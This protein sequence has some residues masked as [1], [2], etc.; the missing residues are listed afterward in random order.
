MLRRLFKTTALIL[1]SSALITGLTGCSANPE[2]APAIQ[3]KFTQVDDMQDN[4]EQNNQLLRTITSDLAILKDQLSNMRAMDPNSEAGQE[5]LSRLEMIE[6]QV[7]NIDAESERMISQLASGNPTSGSSNSSFNG[8]A[9][10]NTQQSAP[11]QSSTPSTPQRNTGMDR[12]FPPDHLDNRS[13][14]SNTSSSNSSSAGSTSSS[15]NS[16]SSPSTPASTTT[17]TSN[18]SS[19]AASTSS[20]SAS[21]GFYYTLK[22]GETLETVAEAN[23]I[24]IEKLRQENRIPNGAR[25][26]KGQR[27]YVPGS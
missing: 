24:T 18:S 9:V 10:P 7:G 27:I 12:L 8:L 1:S 20:S 15:S 2:N 25:V 22:S 6:S 5:L 21:R 13:R 16:S 19:S 4:L 14:N 11:A 17:S 3:K 23:G 26:L